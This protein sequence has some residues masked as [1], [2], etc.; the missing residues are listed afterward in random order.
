M[1]EIPVERTPAVERTE[2]V[3]LISGHAV[4]MERWS[5]P[6]WWGALHQLVMER[7]SG[8]PWWGAPC[9]NVRIPGGA[10]SC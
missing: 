4:L 10:A 9:Q 2:V 7:W 5:G 3:D 8:L 1:T 6:P